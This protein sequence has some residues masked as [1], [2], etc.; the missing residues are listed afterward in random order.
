MTKSQKIDILYQKAKGTKP[1]L[2]NEEAIEL[3]RYRVELREGDFYTTKANIKDYVNAVDNEGCLLPFYDWCMNNNRADRRRKG[4]SEGALAKSNKEDNIGT[5]VGG[6]FTWGIAVYWI[7]QE[8][9]PIFICG[10]VG[11]VISVFL[12]KLNRKNSYFKLLGLPI[13]I[14]IFFA[15]R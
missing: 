5:M 11:A 10:M 15:S 14:A 6:F 13:L 3:S 4:G 9:L 8:S 12:Y 7:F 2:T 1:K